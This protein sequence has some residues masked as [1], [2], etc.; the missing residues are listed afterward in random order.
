MNE[1][2]RRREGGTIAIRCVRM[3]RQERERERE[4]RVRERRQVGCATILVID[5]R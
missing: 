2:E 4:E 1:R 3:F 5:P